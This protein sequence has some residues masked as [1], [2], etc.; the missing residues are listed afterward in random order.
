MIVLDR[1]GFGEITTRLSK[2]T[3]LNSFEER[4]LAVGL[5]YQSLFGTGRL[6]NLI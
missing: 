1:M 2:P 6:L 3:R 5:S 4:N